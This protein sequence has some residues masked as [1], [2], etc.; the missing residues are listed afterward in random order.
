MRL[1]STV[2][3]L[4]LVLIDAPK[5]QNDFAKSIRTLGVSRYGYSLLDIG[6]D[7]TLGLLGE[8]PFNNFGNIL[9]TIDQFG[10][11]ISVYEINTTSTTQAFF[12]LV[13]DYSF[14]N[15]YHLIMKH[16][17]S[18]EFEQ[19]F[20]GIIGINATDATYWA[21]RTGSSNLNFSHCNPF[22]SNGNL[23]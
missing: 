20:T 23:S 7:T 11:P 9:V 12:N 14:A 8:N 18:I 3:L 19:R 21:K 17:Q 1:A 22:R 5:S 13:R 4:C 2:I 15:N 10:N 16:A 6:E